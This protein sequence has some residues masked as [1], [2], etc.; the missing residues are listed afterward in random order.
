MSPMPTRRW[1][2]RS[3]PFRCWKPRPG[4]V[5]LTPPEVPVGLPS[6]LLKRRPDIR[7]AAAQ[8]HAAN[9]QIGVAKA[10]L[11]PQFSLTGSINYQSDLVR[12]MFAGANRIWAAGPSVNWAIL[13]GGAIE[14]N[15]RLQK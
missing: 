2:R 15:V 6:D 13:Q 10:D 3:R 1:R 12:T 11:F 8:W 5:P 9:A 4:P 14:A 7:E